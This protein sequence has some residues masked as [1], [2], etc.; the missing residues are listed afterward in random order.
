MPDDKDPT[1]QRTGRHGGLQS[2]SNTD[3]RH[4]RH[5][6]MAHVRENSPASPSYWARKLGIP[7]TS[8][9]DLTTEQLK[10]IKTAQKLYF[11]K[12]R[13][14]S[15]KAKKRKKADRLRQLA[16]AIDAEVEAGEAS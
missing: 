14:E 1:R 13:T 5:Q 9:K 3:E 4:E 8:L 7:F 16:D 15:V 11:A 6:R 12:L 2:W 10:E